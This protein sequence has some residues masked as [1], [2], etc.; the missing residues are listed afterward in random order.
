MKHRGKGP[1]EGIQYVGADK[2][3]PNPAAINAIQ[4]SELVII[5]PGN[6]LTSIGPML[7]I[8]GVRKELSKNRKKVVAVSP[9]VGDKSFSGPAAQYMEAAGIQVSVFGI[10]QMYADVCSKLVIDSKDRSQAKKIESMDMKVYD[11]K[12]KMTNKAS[13]EALASFIL[14]QVKG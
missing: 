5:A 3:R 14:K 9:I 7:G 8:K 1:I 4:D 2:S 11:T 12:I 10:G 13:E 6:P